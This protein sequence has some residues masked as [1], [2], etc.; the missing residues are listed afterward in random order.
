[1]EQWIRRTL[2]LAY[3]WMPSQ[4]S[5]KPI[6]SLYIISIVVSATRENTHTSLRSEQFSVPNIKLSFSSLTSPLPNYSSVKM[7]KQALLKR[8]PSMTLEEFSAAWLRHGALVTPYF[9]SYGCQ[10]YAQV[11]LPLTPLP[12]PSHRQTKTYRSTSLSHPQTQLSSLSSRN[13]FVSLSY[14]RQETTSP[15][16]LTQ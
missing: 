16:L 7:Q 5:Q 10:Y 15:M 1:M 9:L 3:L 4:D 6:N 12:S 2:S 8:N 11:L 13:G 14:S